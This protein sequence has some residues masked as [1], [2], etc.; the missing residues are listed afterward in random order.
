MLDA[1][2]A[3]IEAREVEQVGGELREPVDLLAHRLEELLPGRLVDLLVR[4][5]LEEAAEREERRPQLVRG[6][7][8]EL[9]ARAVEL[10]EPPAHSLERVGQVAELVVARVDHRLVEASARDPLGRPLEPQDA[11]AHAA[12][13]PGSR[14]RRRRAGA[15]R[16]ANRSRRSI[17]FRLAIGSASES[18]SRITT[19]SFSSGIATS[20]NRRA[21]ARR[22]CR[23]RACGCAS[24]RSA[25][26]SRATSSDAAVFESPNT[27]GWFCRIEKTTTRAWKTE[28]TCSAN[29][30]SLPTWVC[31]VARDVLRVRLE[32]VELGVDELV[33]E[34][35]DDD[36]VDDAERAGDDDGQRE[37]EP[38]PDPAIRG[39]CIA[40][41]RSRKR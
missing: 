21:A 13:R 24:P 38:E 5:Q 31:V 4:H 36:Q 10:A 23:A 1:H 32:L 34:R 17:S 11:L 7:G 28:A 26:G 41:Q 27:N 9:A 8:D 29:S 25:I 2:P 35:G 40:C 19:P 18:L 12:M 6:V 14:R 3:R 33:L 22:R 20:A 16:P 39:G 15:I 30:C 37:R